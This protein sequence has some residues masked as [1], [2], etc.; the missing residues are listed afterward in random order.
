[1][2]WFGRGLG[3][4][5][6]SVGEASNINQDFRANQQDMAL[7]AARQKITDMMAPLQLQELQQRIKQ[8]GQPQQAG[9]VP[10]QNG[11]RGGVTFNP[12]DGTYSIQNLVPG[13]P[14]EPKFPNLQAAAA[15]Y[16]QK[17]DLP[18]LKL[19]N[20]EIDRTKTQK[21]AAEPKDP[22]EAWRAQNKDAPISDW[23]KLQEKFKKQ[24]AD[25]NAAY[26]RWQKEQEYKAAHPIPGESGD[27]DALSYDI[28][29]GRGTMPT[30]KF[31][32]AV[33][34]RMKELG[35]EPPVKNQ[36]EVMKAAAVAQK[37][38]V[39]SQS[40]DRIMK[41]HNLTPSDALNIAGIYDRLKG[42]HVAADWKTRLDSTF[43]F[44]PSKKEISELAEEINNST[45]DVRQQAID[46]YKY[47]G[48]PVPPAL[49]AG[50]LSDL[51][52]S[53]VK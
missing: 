42:T 16:L 15:Y 52:A 40:V 39:A 28:A 53:P 24:P 10:L 4:F 11:G 36:Q 9:I 18:N 35:L 41:N 30:G 1:M 44:R 26:D 21:P 29:A 50:D 20:D 37:A 46:A 5:G 49:T 47:A 48:M 13:A 51:G 6:N 32:A 38:M 12:S 17:G 22:F 8:M 7:K 34:N 2:G 19:V 45:D 27:V 14:Q 43:S 33:A 23:F 3:D 31:G 25:Q